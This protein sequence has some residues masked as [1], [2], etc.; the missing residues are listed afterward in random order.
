MSALSVALRTHGMFLLLLEL[1]STTRATDG[2][3]LMM[4]L[5]DRKVLI[6]RSSKTRSLLYLGRTRGAAGS[7]APS[8]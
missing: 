1:L 4:L 2:P 6:G 7:T 3:S 8:P 5:K